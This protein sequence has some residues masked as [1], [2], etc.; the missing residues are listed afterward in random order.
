MGGKN[1]KM[2]EY[3]EVRKEVVPEFIYPGKIKRQESLWDVS[4]TLFNVKP[5]I[6]PVNESSTVNFRRKNN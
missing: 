3:P 6:H 5:A 1:S 4:S 2:I